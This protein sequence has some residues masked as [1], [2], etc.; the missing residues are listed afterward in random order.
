MT[1]Q[2]RQNQDNYDDD[3]D[4]LNDALID[5]DDVY[6]DE[7][8]QQS[9]NDYAANNPIPQLYYDDFSDDEL[10]QEGLFQRC[11]V[12]ESGDD[13]ECYIYELDEDEDDDSEGSTTTD[14]PTST[15]AFSFTATFNTTKVLTTSPPASITATTRFQSNF[16]STTPPVIPSSTS[17]PH[18]SAG[19]TIHS[20]APLLL[21]LGCM[22]CLS[23]WRG[24]AYLF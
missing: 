19:N 12:D 7:E 2:T 23:S 20:Q 9:A 14:A 17:K 21:A 22:F 5:Y 16:S 10:T 15:D 11:F 4:N 8:D 6:S 24:M 13:V 3:T 18:G 1:I